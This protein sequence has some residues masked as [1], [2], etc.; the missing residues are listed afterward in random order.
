[1]NDIDFW[2]DLEEMDKRTRE[3]KEG[4]K[5]YCKKYIEVK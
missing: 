4:F 5:E 3:Y 2:K 1:M